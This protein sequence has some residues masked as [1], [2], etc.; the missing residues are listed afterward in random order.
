MAWTAQT[1]VRLRA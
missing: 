1:A